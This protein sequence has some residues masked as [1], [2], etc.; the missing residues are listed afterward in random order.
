LREQVTSP[1]GTTQ[2]ALNTFEQLG[3]EATFREAMRS[4]LNRAEEMAIDFSA[5]HELGN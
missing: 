3:L 2:A 5:Q 4:A 1:G